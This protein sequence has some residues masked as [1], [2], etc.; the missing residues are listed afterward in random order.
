MLAFSEANFFGSAPVFVHQARKLQAGPH[1]LD[2]LVCG[3][4]VT[5]AALLAS[6]LLS[7][8]L[9]PFILQPTAIPSTD[10]EWRCV[11]EIQARP[12]REPCI[13]CMYYPMEV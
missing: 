3:F 12:A 6:E 13:T 11:E 10:P 4:T 7:L 9:V 2:L 5:G 1:P 8:P